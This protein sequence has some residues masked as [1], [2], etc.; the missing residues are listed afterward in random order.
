MSNGSLIRLRASEEEKAGRPSHLSLRYLPIQLAVLAVMLNNWDFP[1]LGL[2]FSDPLVILGIVSLLFLR[3]KL[4]VSHYLIVVL[5][6]AVV[7][8]NIVAASVIDGSYSM[9]NG[10]L[11]LGKV[12]LYA[13]FIL[14]LYNYVVQRGFLT[15]ALRILVA[16]TLIAC[17]IG[18]YI[19]FVLQSG[20]GLPYEFFWEF[21]RKDQASYDFGDSSGIIRNRSIFSE[22]QH[23]GFFLN[24]VLLFCMFNSAKI[25]VSNPVLVIISVTA[26]TTLSFSTLPITVVLIAAYILRRHNVAGAVVLGVGS[27]ALVLLAGT[28]PFAEAIR[29]TIFDRFDAI[30]SGR[31]GSAVSRLSGSWD[32]FNPDHILT[33]NG[34]GSTPDIFNNYAYALTELGIF[35]LLL[36]VLLSV[37]LLRRNLALGLYFIFF[38]ATKGGYLSAYYWVFLAFFFIFSYTYSATTTAASR[39]SAADPVSKKKNFTLSA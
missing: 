28:G 30:V 27:V 15:E 25:R 3:P 31:D 33:G 20:I 19:T 34:I 36:M 29:T 11:Y 26:I 32:Y 1:A 9:T 37:I 16:W 14:M 18:L 10:S 5:V 21:T 6:G 4:P 22:P 17:G 13:L 7:G 39:T 23:F 8:A 12:V 35:P 38:T 2:N 24:T